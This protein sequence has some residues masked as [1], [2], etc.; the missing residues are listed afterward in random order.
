[1]VPLLIAIVALSLVPGGPPA[2]VQ[3]AELFHAAEAGAIQVN[4]VAISKFLKT[5]VALYLKIFGRAIFLAASL[6]G[7]SWRPRSGLY[8][9]EVFP[10]S[11]GSNGIGG[12][13]PYAVAAR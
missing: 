10:C 1:M 5:I 3:L 7:M 13:A 4:D 8:V 6:G 9:V 11:G 2:G 12:K